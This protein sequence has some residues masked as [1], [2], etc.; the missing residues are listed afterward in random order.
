M[1][2]QLDLFDQAADGWIKKL[3]DQQLAIK[4]N[5][6]VNNR[7]ERIQYNKTN[8]GKGSVYQELLKKQHPNNPICFCGCLMVTRVNKTSGSSFWG[9]SNYPTC[10][11]TQQIKS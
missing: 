3:K 9:C 2:D 8:R 10:T 11:N 1:A 6:F 7:A 4:A 5:D